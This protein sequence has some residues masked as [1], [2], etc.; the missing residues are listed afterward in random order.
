MKKCGHC[1]FEN[2]D[3]AT[4]CVTCHTDLTASVSDAPQ[5]QTWPVTP[6]DE[7]RFWERMTFRQFAALFLRLQALWLFWYA[8]LDLTYVPA[9]LGRSYEGG[10]YLSPGS[11]LVFFMLVIRIIMHVAAGMAVLQ[12]TDPLL[13]WL[14]KDLIRS[15]P[16]ITALEPTATA[17]SVSYETNNPKS[18][19]TFTSPSADGGST[20]DR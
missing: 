9:Y 6:L 3:E 11:R 15:Q 4:Q 20:L 5:Q 17:P 18:A 12:F 10:I 1:G 2:P 7:R 19:A 8:A 13:N 16:P 14:V